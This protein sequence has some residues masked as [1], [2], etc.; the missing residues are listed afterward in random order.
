LPQNA[1]EIRSFAYYEH[2]YHMLLRDLDSATVIGDVAGW[3][4]T[5]GQP[6]LSG[7]DRGA[8]EAVSGGTNEASLGAR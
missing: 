6:L 8:F 2:G 7:A 5:P 4:L 1:T 3:V